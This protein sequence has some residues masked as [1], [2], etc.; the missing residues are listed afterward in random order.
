MTQLKLATPT[1]RT[2][3]AERLA[4]AV[5]ARE[6]LR[7]EHNEMGRRFREKLIDR[8]AW[9]AYRETFEKKNLAISE[10]LNE[11]RFPTEGKPD[12]GVP[13]DQLASVDV[14]RDFEEVAEATRGA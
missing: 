4:F 1:T 8:A 10:T 3:W 12:T 6:K 2:S 9:E 11:L 13:A 5:A 14:S 7:Q